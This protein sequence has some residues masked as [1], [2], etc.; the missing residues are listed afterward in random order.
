MTRW[1]RGDARPLAVRMSVAYA[2][3]CLALWPIPVFGLL[4]AESSAVIAGVGCFG[5][6][7]LGTRVGTSVSLPDAA[8]GL[9]LASGVPL[10]LLLASMLW[11]PN[12]GWPQGLAFYA[13]FVPPSVLFGL[14]VGAAV[15]A[16]DVRWPRA[17][18]AG[19]VLG[20]ALGGVVLD[21][22]FHPQLF[23][24][25]HV[26]GGVVGP[27]YDEELAMRPGLFAAKAQTLL[28]VAS[29]LAIASWRRYRTRLSTWMSAAAL[30]ALGASYAAGA[31]LGIVQSEAGI[32]SVLSERV[33]LGPVVLHLA[34][35][36]PEAERQ[37]V[38]EE[39]LFRFETLAREL[40]VVPDEPVNIYLYPDP[41]TKGALIGS[42]TTS[43]VPVWLPSPQVH[44]LTEEVGR[45]LAHELVHVLA[46]EFGMPV[47]RASPAVGLVEGLAVAL[48]PPD[49]LPG[50]EALVRAGAELSGDGAI[51]PAEAVRRTMSPTGFW[52]ARSGVAYTANGAFVRWLLDEF[53]PEP[54]KEAYRSGR[55]APTFGQSLA[56]LASSWDRDLR[57]RAVDPEAV[58]VA[59]WL[60]SR[61]SLFERRCPHFVPSDTRQVRAGDEARERGEVAA[62]GEA[63]REAVALNPY[64]LDALR[65]ALG[66]GLAQ[67]IEPT[68]QTL[69]RAEALADSLPSP[70]VL[71][72]L[73][74]VRRLLAMDAD[75]VYAAARDSLAPVDGVGR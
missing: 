18:A 15:S 13:L 1:L 2:V 4:H 36:T 38:A 60:F 8:R 34:P 69:T 64:R 42:R 26:F 41:D 53:G 47:I 45:S 57:Q 75:A 37:R 61:P 22:R 63:Y 21:L 12:C 35:D 48:E 24:Y 14:A 72:H 3:V 73:A 30:L 39:A 68:R 23:T 40:D 51:A 44:M 56:Q 19:V 10:L 25:S 6:A 50:P 67:G 17:T 74:D 49:G 54:V 62:A 70:A 55:F 43:V 28:W 65:G 46:R 58:A 20:A 66:T 27:I 11:R 32:Q 29:L 71:L 5:A 33:D 31:P 7:I 59:E 52:T 16:F 9:L